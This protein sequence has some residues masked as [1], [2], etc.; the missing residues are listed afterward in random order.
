MVNYRK[1]TQVLSIA[2]N[3]SHVQYVGLS[4]KNTPSVTVLSHTTRNDVRAEKMLH[5]RLVRW[6]YVLS[7]DVFAMINDVDHRILYFEIFQPMIC[8]RSLS[9]GGHNIVRYRMIAL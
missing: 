6:A 5:S 4:F 2:C 3:R 1:Q 7:Y 9:H 8:Q